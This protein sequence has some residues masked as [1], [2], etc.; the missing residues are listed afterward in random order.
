MNQL[1]LFNTKLPLTLNGNFTQG[2]SGWFGSYIRHGVTAPIN[3]FTPAYFAT[4]FSGEPADYLD[5]IPPGIN[6]FID[7]PELYTYPSTRKV[8]NLTM[9]VVAPDQAVLSI[10][11][12]TVFSTGAQATLETHP[13]V[14]KGDGEVGVAQGTLVTLSAAIEAYSGAA[15]CAK[16]VAIKVANQIVDYVLPVVLVQ[17]TIAPILSD[18]SFA[19]VT[20]ELIGVLPTTGTGTLRF[21]SDEATLNAIKDFAR[22]DGTVGFRIG[23]TIQLLDSD[24][25]VRVTAVATSL[26]T[27]TGPLSYNLSVA[28][29]LGLA[30]PTSASATYRWNVFP[31]TYTTA[32]YTL[33]VY[34]YDYTLALSYEAIEGGAPGLPQIQFRQTESDT[35]RGIGEEI[36]ATT[37]TAEE[38]ATVTIPLP[39]STWNRRIT[40]L[41]KEFTKPVRGRA[42]LNI[43]PSGFTGF[44]LGEPVQVL[45]VAYDAVMARARI[46][47][48]EL[49]ESGNPISALTYSQATSTLTIVGTP[50]VPL[51]LVPGQAIYLTG[52]MLGMPQ[53]L[54]VPISDRR[55]L[56][57][58][59]YDLGTNTATALLATPHTD[60]PSLTGLLD[61][62]LRVSETAARQVQLRFDA[63]GEW[64]LR[65]QTPASGAPVTW[66]APLYNR[67][68]RI[69]ATPVI[70]SVDTFVSAVL[71]VD[72]DWPAEPPTN[73]ITI[74]LT[75]GTVVGLATSSDNV[76]QIADV[77]LWRGYHIHR[78]NSSD[79]ADLLTTNLG[80]NVSI[81]PL[82]SRV[83]PIGDIVPK[84]V[85]M[86]YT[87][88]TCPAGYKPVDNFADA[89]PSTQGFWKQPTMPWPDVVTYNAT[90]DTTTLQWPFLRF[91]QTNPDG[92]LILKNTDVRYLELP[93]VDINPATGERLTRQVTIKQAKQ[94]VEPGMF[95]SVDEEEYVEGRSTLVDSDG[96]MTALD[97][98]GP[99]AAN[100]ASFL[101]TNLTLT[102]STDTIE[103]PSTQPVRF[104]DNTPSLF[105]GGFGH[106]SYPSVDSAVF[107]PRP[108]S[109]SLSHDIGNSLPNV[110]TAGPLMPRQTNVFPGARPYAYL[111]IN[112]LEDVNG[113]GQGKYRCQRL[114]FANQPNP[115][116]AV[117]VT[118]T[119]LTAD[120]TANDDVFGAL[121]TDRPESI[122]TGDVFFARIYFHLAT[123]STTSEWT[124]HDGYL[125]RLVQ[126]SGT[127]W[128]VYRYDGAAHRLYDVGTVG[129]KQ[130]N[131]VGT[132]AN[133]PQ[134][135]ISGGIIVLQPAKLY[136]NPSNRQEMRGTLAQFGAP[137]QGVALSSSSP[138]GVGEGYLQQQ[139]ALSV[140]GTAQLAWVSA[141]VQVG[142]EMVVTGNLAKVGTR[143]HLRV[144]PSGYLRYDD[145]ST[146]IHYGASGHA[147]TI[148]NTQDIQ[149]DNPLPRVRSTLLAHY[150]PKRL[151]VGH[152]HGFLGDISYT[153]PAAYLFTLCEKL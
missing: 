61:S 59:S 66:A 131:A 104:G 54:R 100:R 147:H 76:C 31:V 49:G 13:F 153:M 60:Q 21:I 51:N 41:T 3:E 119:N 22:P 136:G 109:A 108:V 56:L 48:R 150:P 68:S 20:L 130:T 141:M 5:T 71:Y 16:P 142:T 127:S 75:D 52:K 135:L 90:T 77:A 79:T 101:I 10:N 6:Q 91:N 120:V 29:I 106:I 96:D 72:V 63:T 115:P 148:D 7:L 39:N 102:A 89:E 97:L 19:A 11:P 121:G 128:D 43:P 129:Y 118:G 55:A 27:S 98:Y 82:L 80:T 45:S 62:T 103:A 64:Q 12:S 34:K 124:Y 132:S 35:I 117:P 113:L 1:T 69:A 137:G 58:L 83:D 14:F 26:N 138:Q 15:R 28:P 94:L 111:V 36:P 133:F 65:L 18:K 2:L 87:G 146:Q 85:V 110:P 33:D 92:S 95:L 88:G 9:R 32:T 144:E 93:L 74:N 107:V 126:R 152:G 44:I 151:P 116:L 122:R 30:A 112:T 73:P 37:I 67:N 4:L 8:Y 78:M 149:L 143:T 42:L 50:S 23:D 84:G 105:G 70:E 134:L 145:P 125:V 81:D 123:S 40:Y 140:S 86:L 47:Y 46:R 38:Q 57:V 99:V 25:A 53:W 114:Q 24:R 17:R 139:T